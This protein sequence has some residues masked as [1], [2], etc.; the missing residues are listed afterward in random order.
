MLSSVDGFLVG[1]LLQSV[2]KHSVLYLSV[3]AQRS[4][5]I[6]G[7]VDQVTRR[8]SSGNWSQK[9]ISLFLHSNFFRWLKIQTS[10]AC[11]VCAVTMSVDRTERPSLLQLRSCLPHCDC[12]N[13]SSR[14]RLL[15]A[16]GRRRAQALGMWLWQCLANF[17]L[18]P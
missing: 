6:A 9:M 13:W 18:V 15:S 14:P 16:A 11:P 17:V 3:I 2:C 10:A 8:R 12:Q 5:S 1:N 7:R 4:T